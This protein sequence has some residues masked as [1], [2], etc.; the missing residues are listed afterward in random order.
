MKASYT[1]GE[2]KEKF[3]CFT[4]VEEEGSTAKCGAGVF[5]KDKDLYFY[6]DRNYIEIG[7]AFKGKL[8][9][10]LLGA[11]RTSLFKTLGSP[12]IKDDTWDAYQM[13]Y[14]VMVLHYTGGKVKRIQI[15][16]EN[17][18]TLRLCE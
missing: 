3:P 16:T 5:F 8:S 10:P 12:Q 17:S 7:P 13:A 11:A 14:G 9:I 6:T 2:I 4:S 15:S 1:L 18:S